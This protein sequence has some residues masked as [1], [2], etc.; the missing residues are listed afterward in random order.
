M[1]SRVTSTLA[2]LALAV[3]IGAMV[4]MARVMKGGFS[5]RDQPSRLEA[6]L[7]GRMRR[8]ATPRGMRHLPNPVPATP[9]V[10]AGARAHFADHCA[11][12]HGNDGKGNTVIGRNLYPRVPDM[13][14]PATQSL[15]DGELFFIIH[16]GIRL[17]GMPAWGDGSADD[18]HESWELVHFIRHLPA[19]TPEEL[20]EMETLNPKSRRELEQEEETRRFLEGAGTAPAPPSHHH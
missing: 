12:C 8:M 9:E 11:S 10:L 18:D 4:T 14:R 2:L 13:T 3:C 20:E 19:L 17:T 15:S 16:N 5:A 1:K 7:A 6:F